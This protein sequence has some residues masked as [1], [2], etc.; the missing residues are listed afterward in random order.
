MHQQ[1]WDAAEA[2]IGVFLRAKRFAE[3]ETHAERC[4]RI[5]NVPGTSDKVVSSALFYLAYCKEMKGDKDQARKLYAESLGL[6][7]AHADGEVT[8]DMPTT[9]CYLAKLYADSEEY[10]LAEPILREVLAVEG[11]GDPTCVQ[12]AANALGEL[13]EKTD[14]GEEALK[15]YRSAVESA[16]Q[17]LGDSHETTLAYLGNLVPALMAEGELTEAFELSSELLK[18]RREIRGEYHIETVDIKKNSALILP[19][20]GFW[21]EAERMQRDVLRY[22]DGVS[23][24][25]VMDICFLLDALAESCSKQA[26]YPE[27]EAFGRR[28][29]DLRLTHDSISDENTL[30]TI[31]NLAR[32]LADAGKAE[33]AEQLLDLVHDTCQHASLDEEDIALSARAHLRLKQS[34]LPEA[35]SLQERIVANNR[36]DLDA[37]ISL[38]QLHQRLGQ[39]GE[40][41]RVL[42]NAS[43]VAFSESTNARGELEKMGLV[44]TFIAQL[45]LDTAVGKVGDS[46][47]GMGRMALARAEK[48]CRVNYA[49]GEL[50]SRGLGAMK[51]LYEAMGNV[52]EVESTELKVS[53]IFLPDNCVLCD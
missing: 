3:A 29:M 26:H 19:L 49:Y 2:L 21:P 44:R 13:C 32:I 7:R 39:H 35:L 16:R 14:R 34:R 8:A 40:A 1:A 27:A 28:A 11:K 22:L 15:Y 4:M 43:S 18:R 17:V 10:E 41:S 46:A 24:D 25:E 38:A 23:P 42:R 50:Y 36:Y 37:L 48:W 6:L 47:V 30:R 20:L 33:E 12:M 5:A 45:R 53:S 9:M 51:E 52:R 31:A